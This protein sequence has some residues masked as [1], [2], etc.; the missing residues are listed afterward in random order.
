MRSNLT[1][2]AI[3]MCPYTMKADKT[4]RYLL[5]FEIRYRWVFCQP[6]TPRQRL[7]SSVRLTLEELP[8]SLD[9]THERIVKDTRESNISEAYRFLQSF[10]VAIRPLFV[11]NLTEPLAFYFATANT[12]KRGTPEL[13]TN[14]HCEDHGSAILSICSSLITTLGSGGSGVVR[15]SHF[16]VTVF[17]LSDLLPYRRVPSLGVISSSKSPR[18]WF[19]GLSQRSAA[20]SC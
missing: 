7:P 20:G 1:H 11:V 4:W 5:I 15:F 12:A 16:S 17:L 2:L 18:R 19:R 9:E 14:W 10:A 3:S 6:D 8:E 13:N